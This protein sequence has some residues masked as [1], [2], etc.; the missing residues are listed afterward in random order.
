MET[1]DD[2]VKSAKQ[3][4]SMAEFDALE[5][6]NKIDSLLPCEFAAKEVLSQKLEIAN[7]DVSNAVRSRFKTID[8]VAVMHSAKK[9]SN[10]PFPVPRFA[11]FDTRH[12]GI[13]LEVESGRTIY[14]GPDMENEYATHL[15]SMRKFVASKDMMF[16]IL[17]RISFLVPAA[18][19]YALYFLSVAPSL[20]GI[21]ALG[22]GAFGGYVVLRSFFDSPPTMYSVKLHAKL[23]GTIPD[24]IREL[25]RKEK[26]NFDKILILAAAPEWSLEAKRQ[27][28][29][30]ADPLVIG[31]KR[32]KYYLLG[33]FDLTPLEKWLEAEF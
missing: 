19:S 9:Q 8:V 3:E 28:V 6:R 22:L 30:Q 31:Q 26:N 20:T 10:I 11:L 18:I 4:T 1:L 5:L 14:T 29:I 17:V 15:E 21:A 7:S 32:N 33:K 2:I 16:N 13:A 25:I 23:G 27:V 24:N 12:N